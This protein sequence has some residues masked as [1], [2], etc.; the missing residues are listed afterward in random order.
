MKIVDNFLTKEEFSIVK[1]TLLGILFPWYVTYGIS[2]HRFDDFY[3]EEGHQF[4]HMFYEDYKPNSQYYFDLMPLFLDKIQPKS[5]IRIKAN[6]YPYF[7]KYVEHDMHRDW[8]FP[9]QGALF[10]VNT[11]NGYTILNDGTKIES[12]ENRIAFFDTHELHRS[13]NCTDDKHRVV[14]NFNFF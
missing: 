14:I 7:G 10:Y 13:T 11:N 8:D 2:K 6:L 3:K 5:L 1:E 4:V 12:I 9:H